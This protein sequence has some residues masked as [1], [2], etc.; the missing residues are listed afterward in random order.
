MKKRWNSEYKYYFLIALLGL[1]VMVSM[2]S[3]TYAY[4]NGNKLVAEVSSLSEEEAIYKF[5]D[6]VADSEKAVVTEEYEM[7]VL[8]IKPKEIV[9]ASKDE[10]EDPKKIEAN[11]GTGKETTASEAIQ[12]YETNETSLGIDVSTWNGKIDWKKVKDSGI[13][14]A[15]IRIG[16]R[17]YQSGQ[18]MMDNTFYQN[19]QGALANN[20]N[21]GIYFFTAAVT[22]SEAREEAA[23]VAEIIKNYDISYP[24]AY[25]IEIF[26][27]RD[28]TR[29]S[30]LSDHQIT[31]NSL[32]FCDYIRSKGYTPMIYSYYNAF[33]SRLE[34]GRFGSNRV[35]LAH[36]ADSTNYKGNY[37]MWQYTSSGSVPGINGRVDMNVSYFSVTND[38]TKRQPVNGVNSDA[39]QI[40]LSFKDVNVAAQILEDTYLRTTPSL[41]VP[42]KAGSVSTGT[43]ITITGV[44]D[45]F[46]R[47]QFEG[48]TYYLDSINKVKLPDTV[49][50]KNNIREEIVLKV[51][52]K[53][54]RKP[55]YYLYNNTFDTLRAGS[56]LVLLGYNEEYLKVE[57][58]GEVYY[59]Y[60]NSTCYDNYV[61][62]VANEDPVN[63]GESNENNNNTSGN[64]DNNNENEPV[65]D[66][67][68]EENLANSEQ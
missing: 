13:K 68:T 61:P 23:W 21:V 56:R 62:E 58:N 19:I 36:Y 30:G 18:I 45:T 41:S 6:N 43:S 66:D 55:Y 24:I 38:I 63:N 27:N 59:V 17:G 11:K 10:K 47:I 34:V 16:F 9:V 53:L 28:D 57:Y 31:N 49:W 35:W 52:E 37:H 20:I 51:E 15:M 2:I 46:I 29:M 32:A 48:N 60:D 54:Y 5:L 4:S 39:N 26:G 7:P 25:D 22:E 64:D 12:R 65:S 14:F 33:N 1:V 40:A 50:V 8:V 44:S 67:E 3:F 42:N